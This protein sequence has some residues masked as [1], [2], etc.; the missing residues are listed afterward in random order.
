MIWCENDFYVKFYDMAHI[1]HNLMGQNWIVGV[2][3]EP[4]ITT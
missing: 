4:P 1:C 2:V 3:D